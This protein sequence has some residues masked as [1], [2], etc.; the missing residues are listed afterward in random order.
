[1]KSDE[2]F[3]RRGMRFFNEE[4][5]EEAI[6]CFKRVVVY[7]DSQYRSAAYATIANCLLQSEDFVNIKTKKINENYNKLIKE[8]LDKALE[9]KPTNQA[10]KS[11]YFYYN[12]SNR[13]YKEALR[14]FNELKE[15][16]YIK[17]ILLYLNI[18]QGPVDDDML[19]LFEGIYK[20]EKYKNVPQIQNVLYT[21]YVS[22]GDTLKAYEISKTFLYKNQNDVTALLNFSSTCN[23]I[24]NPKESKKYL[25]KAEDII[26]KKLNDRFTQNEEKNGLKMQKYCLNS[27]KGWTY[28]LLG[29]Y[30]DVINILEDNV[31]EYPNNTDYFNLASSY[32]KLKEY[33]KSIKNCY[34]ALY[35]LKDEV[36]FRLLGDNYYAIKDYNKSQKCY[37]KALAFITE[38]NDIL[39]YTEKNGQT[40][41]SIPIDKDKNLE[42]I[43]VNLIFC[44]IQCKDYIEAQAIY[45]I[46]VEKFPN[47]QSL[48]R[49][50][51]TIDLFI[52][53]EKNNE[54]TNKQILELNKTLAQ[55]KKKY[56]QTLDKCNEWA[57]S[58][59][60]LQNKYEGLTINENLWSILD[61]EMT[62]VIQNM[63]SENFESNE[64]NYK[65][66]KSSIKNKFPKISD[67]GLEFLTTSEFL[68]NIHK[69]DIIDYAPIMVEYCK[70]I[71]YEL[72]IFIR[73]HN[74]THRGDRRKYTLGQLIRKIEKLNGVNLNKLLE[75]LNQL[76]VFRN[77]SAH[78]SESTRKKVE[79]ARDMIINKGLLDFILNYK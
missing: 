71:E 58:L 29:M 8:Y 36:T 2:Y 17:N 54:E 57:I 53:T 16:Q 49:M 50:K 28:R 9:I 43:Y 12:Y 77:G 33:N 65:N 14:W 24:N 74:I 63:K 27:V 13:N 64:I 39:E 67:K 70:T 47:S 62:K 78:S 72:N 52:L 32:Y 37:K 55:E 22:K 46:A 5:F 1:M 76:L 38:G 56:A 66:I 41:K 21:T 6:P 31:K 4:K 25:V 48:N 3:Y 69:Q 30:T 10:A 44:D 15:N 73:R 40:F 75:L 34:K 51:D 26:N 35:I 7:E 19:I 59:L 42:Q 23:M 45:N 79:V 11:V 68:F 61:S 18:H 60:K 20:N